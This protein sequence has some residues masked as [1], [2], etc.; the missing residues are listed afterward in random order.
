LN[1]W[2]VAVADLQSG[3]RRALGDL[4][5]ALLPLSVRELHL[6]VRDRLRRAPPQL[7][8]YGYDPFGFNPDVASRLVLPVALLYRHYFRAETHG[9]ERVP[10]GR[11]LLI[12]NHAGQ[13][14]YDGLMLAAAMIL[15]ADPPRLC[16]G[17]GEYFIWKLPW[18]GVTAAR[19]GS[20]VGTPENCA[21]MLE[22]EECVVAFPEG[23]RGI[24]KP[25]RQRYHLERFGLG[26]MRLA[27]AT[28][29]PIVPVAFVG[30][31]EQQPGLANLQ[32]AAD[33]VGLPSLPITVTFPWLGPLGLLVALPVK[34][35]I[36]FGE[37]M[38]FEGDPDEEDAVMQKKVNAVRRVITDLFRR[39]RRERRGLFR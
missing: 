36:Y 29:T 30:S 3:F 14:P 4:A 10:Q 2:K 28:E 35:H 15:D 24:S 25:F 31:E 38:R 7:N 5:G 19:G 23:A 6:E 13:L 8:G 20:I 32:G 1:E 18:L 39:G 22:A 26:F 9:I 34:Y 21:T 16:R 12:A 17:M 37:P 33:A 11:V 27:L